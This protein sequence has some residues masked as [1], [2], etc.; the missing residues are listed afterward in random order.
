MSRCKHD[1]AHESSRLD[2]WWF[3]PDCRQF[4]KKKEVT[5]VRFAEEKH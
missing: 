5:P 1:D 4:L 2:Q 3:C